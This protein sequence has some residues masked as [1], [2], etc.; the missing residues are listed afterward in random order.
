MSGALEKLKAYFTYTGE[1]EYDDYYEEE[2]IF[3]EDD[4]KRYSNNV[5]NINQNKSMRIVLYEP[6]EYEDSPQMAEDLKQGKT[7]IVN[8]N[9][10][11]KE[12]KERVF[13]FLTGAVYVLQG[14]MQKIANEIFVISPGFVEIE[15]VKNELENKGVF[16]WQ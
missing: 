11:E 14:K 4:S 8:L 6:L 5:V 13:A 12:T 10:L 15:G 3:K 9:L 1:D 2:T 7:I 16:L